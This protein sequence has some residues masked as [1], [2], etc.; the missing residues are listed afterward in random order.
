MLMS[1]FMKLDED[2][3]QETNVELSMVLMR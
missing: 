1:K 3:R 2:D